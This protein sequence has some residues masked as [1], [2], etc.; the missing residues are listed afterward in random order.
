MN[1]EFV[2]GKGK[3]SLIWDGKCNLNSKQI[4][5]FEYKKSERYKSVS[6]TISS[7]TLR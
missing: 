5:L 4:Q 2:S 1:N 7:S 6:L 3:N